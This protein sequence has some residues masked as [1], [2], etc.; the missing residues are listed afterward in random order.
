MASPRDP[1]AEVVRRN[2]LHYRTK[3]ALTQEEASQISGVSVDS[4]RR[5]EAGK[6]GASASSLRALAKIYGCR[7]EDFYDEAQPAPDLANRPVIYLRT[8]P[9]VQLEPDVIADLEKLVEKANV[10]ARTKK[11]MTKK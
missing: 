1:E 7:M 2:L 4:I 5:Y 11:K 8:L 10:M 3:A 9:G 6:M